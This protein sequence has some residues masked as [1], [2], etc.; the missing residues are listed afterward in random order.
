MF[1]TR[2][3]T[4]LVILSPIR[5]F[6]FGF[7]VLPWPGNLANS[8]IS[9][10]AWRVGFQAGGRLQSL[11]LRS[12]HPW[13]H[14]DVCDLSNYANLFVFP[15]FMPTKHPMYNPPVEETVHHSCQLYFYSISFFPSVPKRVVESNEDLR[16]LDDDP[17]VSTGCFLPDSEI[18]PSLRWGQDSLMPGQMLSDVTGLHGVLS[19]FFISI[20]GRLRLLLWCTAL[21][22]IQQTWFSR[23]W[24]L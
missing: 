4:I 23:K 20:D 18:C 8:L 1:P 11:G 22:R 5:F 19:L 12:Q 9:W 7:Y 13:M 6:H 17:D 10:P 14:R 15:A 3:V 21:Q 2:F 16:T 24:R